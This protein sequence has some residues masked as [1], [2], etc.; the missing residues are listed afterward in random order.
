MKWPG[1]LQYPQTLVK[2][3]RCLLEGVKVWVWSRKYGCCAPQDKK[4]I[5]EG[6]SESPCSLHDT[7]IK[8][9]EREIKAV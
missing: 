3:L 5:A 2:N 4:N 6:S 7:I 9:M 1:W 8:M